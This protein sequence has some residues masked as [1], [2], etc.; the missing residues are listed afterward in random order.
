VNFAFGHVALL[1]D[2]V[3]H[4]IWIMS[5]QQRRCHGEELGVGGNANGRA[6]PGGEVVLAAVTRPHVRCYVL[7]I[8]QVVLSGETLTDFLGRVAPFGCPPPG[9][10]IRAY[11]LPDAPFPSILLKEHEDAPDGLGNAYRT[12]LD[13]ARLDWLAALQQTGRGLCPVL[14]WEGGAARRLLGPEELAGAARDAGVALPGVADGYLGRG[15]LLLAHPDLAESWQSL[16]SLGGPTKVRKITGREFPVWV[17]LPAHHA[18]LARS[19]LL[20]HVERL[21]EPV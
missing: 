15:L 7:A 17:D 3:R 6:W 19:P 20:A 9:S 5:V 10:L 11:S 4:V 18:S 12:F 13:V 8:P 14:A 16:M 2:D 1:G 21:L